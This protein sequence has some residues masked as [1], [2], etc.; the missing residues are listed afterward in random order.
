[1]DKAHGA[2]ATRRLSSLIVTLSFG[3]GKPRAAAIA[4]KGRLP[5]NHLDRM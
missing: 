5:I 3:E 4:D 2:I 1:M